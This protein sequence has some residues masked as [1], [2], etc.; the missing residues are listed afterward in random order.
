M[1]RSGP[2]FKRTVQ[3]FA[4]K[5]A[6]APYT[7]E[8]AVPGHLV[9]S[10]RFQRFLLSSVESKRDNWK[11][12]SA[13]VGTCI[14]TWTPFCSQFGHHIGVEGAH[15]RNPAARGA[16]APPWAHLTHPGGPADRGECA[17]QPT[18]ATHPPRLPKNGDLPIHPR[19]PWYSNTFITFP[20]QVSTL[21]CCHS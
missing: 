6:F 13:A 1:A 2:F 12:P 11:Q 15:T 8:R 4:R 10:G 18:T 16:G 9:G 21:D 14:H 5:Q 20:G 17:T 19:S 7:Q 3:H